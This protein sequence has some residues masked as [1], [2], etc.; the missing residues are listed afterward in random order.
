[1][2]RLDE[3]APSRSQDAGYSGPI[4]MEFQFQVTDVP[5]NLRRVATRLVESFEP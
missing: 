2:I 3:Q 4:T 1:M 5:A